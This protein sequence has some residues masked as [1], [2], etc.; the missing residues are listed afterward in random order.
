MK[1]ISMAACALC[2]AMLVSGTQVFARGTVQVKK[3]QTGENT[4]IIKKVAAT[5]D[6]SLLRPVSTD[7]TEQKALTAV[8]NGALIQIPYHHTEETV[9]SHNN[10]VMPIQQPGM[11]KSTDDNTEKT[12]ISREKAKQIAQRSAPSG[13]LLK[14]MS[15]KSKN[16]TAYY[17]GW[18]K[19]DGI[20]YA[21]RIDAVSGS[22]IDY[23]TEADPHW[24]PEAHHDVDSLREEDK[25]Y[26]MKWD[27]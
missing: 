20:R 16:G 2:A 27:D 15:L 24:D 17:E 5:T 21:F 6:N 23:T 7:N 25:G 26:K 8:S 12:Y 4:G 3:D 18:L 10:H 14:S 19:K 1:G 11:L 13:A 9:L 22:I